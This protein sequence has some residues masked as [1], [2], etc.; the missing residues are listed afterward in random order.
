MKAKEWKVSSK[1]K[2]AII[3]ARIFIF[4]FFYLVPA[5]IVIGREDAK[6]QEIS[7]GN[8]IVLNFS[9]IRQKK[10]LISA[11]ASKMWSNQKNKSTLSC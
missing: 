8:C 10:S 11:Q 1:S 5:L 4:F 9:E 7:E 6:G 2:L 3:L